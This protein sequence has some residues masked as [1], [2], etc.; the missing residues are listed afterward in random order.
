MGGVGSGAKPK[1]YDPALVSRVEDMYAFGL[2]Q[3]E[4]GD[5]LGLSQKV[6]YNLMRRHEIPTR[7]AA[8]RNQRGELNASWKGSEASYT[9]LHARVYG[10]RGKAS[11]QRCRCGRQ[12]MDWANL[13]GRY[14]SVDD[15]EAMCRPCHRAYDRGVMRD[16]R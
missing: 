8:K 4:I 2:T 11:D 10:V 3:G 6:V 7:T 13:T 12:A 16:A 9:A 14:D 15:F 5:A 1:V